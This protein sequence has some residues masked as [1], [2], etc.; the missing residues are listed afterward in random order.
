MNGTRN[1]KDH[2][3]EKEPFGSFSVVA[4]V[5]FEPTAFGL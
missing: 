1:I 3:N 4:G 5:G 2:Q